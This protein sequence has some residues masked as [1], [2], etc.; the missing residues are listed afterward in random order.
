M[1]EPDKADVLNV[2][3]MIVA[4]AKT[5]AEN[6]D[7]RPFNGATVGEALGNHGASITIL[8]EIIRKLII[9]LEGER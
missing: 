6:F 9:E 2:L 4:D 5:D 7:G 8:A 1:T 3:G